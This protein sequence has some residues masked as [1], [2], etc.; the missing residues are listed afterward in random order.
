MVKQM[1]KG[2]T[3]CRKVTGQRA[4]RTGSTN[5]IIEVRYSGVDSQ[6]III[7]LEQKYFK[8]TAV[9]ITVPVSK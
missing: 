8:V 5:I 6:D 3:G 1:V 4:E 9:E 2:F 7:I